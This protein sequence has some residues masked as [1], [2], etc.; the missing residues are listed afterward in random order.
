VKD[1]DEISVNE[2]IAMAKDPANENNRM[3]YHYILE[4]YKG[5]IHGTIKKKNYFLQGGDYDDL[6]QEGLFGI[7]KAIKDFKKEAG[8]FETFLKICVD[9]QLISAIK[10]STRKKHTPINDMIPLDRSLPENDNLSMMDIFGAREEVQYGI[11]L[12]FTNPEEQM[13]LKEKKKI[14]VKMLNDALSDKEKSV[15]YLYLEGKTYKEIMDELKVDNPKMIDNAIQRVKRKIEK[16]KNCESLE[17]LSDSEIKDMF[18][19]I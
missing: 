6:F 10:T 4:K 9:R 15:C 17:E 13:I 18:K 2:I 19:T 8:E 5:V 16:I 11:D 1:F 7:Y 3:A 14:Q 12:E